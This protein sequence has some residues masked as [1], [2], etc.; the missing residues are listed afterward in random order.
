MP[1]PLEIWMVAAEAAPLVKIGGLADVL[2]SLPAALRV[3][4]ANVRRI[5]PAYGGLDPGGFAEERPME[6]PLGSG[7]VRVRY[8]SRLEA[9]G[10][11]TTLVDCPEVLGRAGVY[12]TPDGD[13]PDNAR[14]FALLARAA[15]ELA[16]TARR[17]PDILHAHDW[18]AALVPVLVRFTDPWPR[19]PRTVLT[20]HNMGYQGRFHAGEIDWLSLGSRAREHLVSI[21]GMEFYGGISFLKG[22]LMF[23]DAITAVSPNYAREIGTP[24]HGHGLDGV[25]RR[26]AG[27]LTGILNG[28]DE[29]IWDPRSDPHLPASYSPESMEGKAASRVKLIERMGLR[30]GPHPIIGFLGRF[31]HQKGADMLA[32]AIP[33]LVAAGASM[34]VVGT[35]ERHIE[36]LFRSLHSRWPDRVGVEFVHSES[37]AHLLTAG[38]DLM[39][40]PSR[41]EP[42]GLVPMHA[43]RY[44][45]PAV[46]HRTGGLAD[47]VRDE[48]ESPGEGT[49]FSFGAL[50]P[51]DLTSAVR[52]AVALKES[53]PDRWL[54]VQRRAMR[55][56]FSWSLAARRYLDLYR[57]LLNPPPY[58]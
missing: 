5:L 55:E 53:D 19:L 25:V 36:D 17:G 51:G 50:S 16:R 29:R 3:E 7:S 52:D 22:G 33:D 32:A 58:S 45:T 31:V 34:A 43:M 48:R 24:D 27:S 12:G 39:V 35:G 42:C 4:G 30:N 2:H 14:R 8:L 13:H 56:C 40:I 6:V 9:D 10:T 38:A 21:E 37:L 23:A 26:R 11:R 46:V 41:Y 28:V 15:V 57:G 47:I 1:H 18:H 44:G 20:I 49:G 54:S